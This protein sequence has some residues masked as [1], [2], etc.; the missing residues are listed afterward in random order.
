[1]C[2]KTLTNY[3]CHLTNQVYVQKRFE[4][5]QK[6]QTTSTVLVKHFSTGGKAAISLGCKKSKLGQI[7]VWKRHVWI[8][9]IV[10]RLDLPDT[11]PG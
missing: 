2:H 4:H 9:A 10:I 7:C 8:A 1:M 3:Q 5:M 6:C 11:P